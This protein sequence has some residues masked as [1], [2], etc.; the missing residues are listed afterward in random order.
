V[1]LAK[2][3]PSLQLVN[4]DVSPEA[5]KEGEANIK[6]LELES[7]IKF[8]YHDFFTPQKISAKAYIFKSILHDWP[9]DA[10][11]KIVKALLP[12]LEDDS[13]VLIGECLMPEA[14]A[15]RANAWDYECKR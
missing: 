10:C 8:A 3:F 5:L 13:H 1:I 14:P 4:Q 2:A 11:V 6:D 15:L 9:D 7:R 12:A